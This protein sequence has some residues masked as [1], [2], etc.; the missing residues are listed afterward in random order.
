MRRILIII[1]LLLSVASYASDKYDLVEI[2]KGYEAD[3]GTLALC[4]YSNV[5]EVQTILI[6]TT[7]KTGKYEVELTR[8]ANDIYRVDGTNI[9]LK[10]RYCYE[11][12]YSDEAI[13]II[14][15]NYSYTKGEVIFLE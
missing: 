11:Y 2:Y 8:V 4:A 7:Q 6:P 9:Y 5:E 14:E 1:C 13:L 12:A 3:S 10:L 15:S